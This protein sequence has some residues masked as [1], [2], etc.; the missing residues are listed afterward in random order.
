MITLASAVE[1]EMLGQ[2][3]DSFRKPPAPEE[4]RPHLLPDIGAIVAK[5]L[6]KEPEKRFKRAGDV[7][8]L[9]N[10]VVD[11]QS[12]HTQAIDDPAIHV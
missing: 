6:A 12:E 2:L 3:L 9:L 11:R 4:H 10:D 5:A 8:T 1:P 7:A